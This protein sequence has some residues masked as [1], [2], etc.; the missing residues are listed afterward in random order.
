MLNR[1]SAQICKWSHLQ[2]VQPCVSLTEGCKQPCWLMIIGLSGYL[3]TASLPWAVISLLMNPCDTRFM[4]SMIIFEQ[5]NGPLLRYVNQAQPVFQKGMSHFILFLR[6]TNEQRPFW[7]C[8]NKQLLVRGGLGVLAMVLC[9]DEI[10][11]MHVFLF[12]LPKQ[13]WTRQK[14]ACQLGG[15]F[16][17]HFYWSTESNFLFSLGLYEVFIQSQWIIYSRWQ[18]VWPQFGKANRRTSTEARQCTGQG[19]QPKQVQTQKNLK[20]I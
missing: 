2:P 1:Y 13:K 20:S 12:F 3:T 4:R 19:Q 11:L 7:Q 5:I 8:P 9:T 10:K 6:G 16:Y 15:A 17:I 14:N 18:S